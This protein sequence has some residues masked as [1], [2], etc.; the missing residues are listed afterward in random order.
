MPAVNEIIV[1]RLSRYAQHLKDGYGKEETFFSR[2]LA[3]HFGY[4]ASLV[5]KDLSCIGRIGVRGGLA[6]SRKPYPCRRVTGAASR[7]TG[8]RR[9]RRHARPPTLR[10]RASSC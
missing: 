4:K 10:L 8:E 7:R 9:A 2:D 1:K 6:W 5:R 3:E